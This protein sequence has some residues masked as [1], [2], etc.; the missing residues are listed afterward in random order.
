MFVCLCVYRSVYNS[1]IIYV[2]PNV[3]GQKDYI[4]QEMVT[5]EKSEHS[6]DANVVSIRLCT[7]H[8]WVDILLHLHFNL[9]SHCFVRYCNCACTLVKSK[10]KAVRLAF[11]EDAGVASC[12]TRTNQYRPFRLVVEPD[13][14]HKLKV[15]H[16][17]LCLYA[18]SHVCFLVHVCHY[19]CVRKVD[20]A[21]IFL[22]YVCMRMYQKPRAV[23]EMQ[24]VPVGGIAGAYDII[25]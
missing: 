15:Y 1:I 14:L 21:N 25:Y 7:D 16:M 5:L 6:M 8:V 3:I 20:A 12:K 4:Q 17:V 9:W 19:V 11:T 2:P 10:V 24:H 18:S 23:P 22:L 13:K